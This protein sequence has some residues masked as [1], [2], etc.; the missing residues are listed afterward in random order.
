[1]KIVKSFALVARRFTRR[2][3]ALSVEGETD[4]KNS[5]GAAAGAQERRPLE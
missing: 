3:R 1:M 2:P 4:G 5:G